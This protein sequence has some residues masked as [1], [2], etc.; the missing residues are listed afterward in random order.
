MGLRPILGERWSASGLQSVR[1]LAPLLFLLV[2]VACQPPP[3]PDVFVGYGE[4]KQVVRHDQRVVIAHEAI[5]DFF[6]AKTSSFAL[7]APALADACVPGQRV[8]FT[9][10]RTSQT[11]YL[12]AVQNVPS[13]EPGERPARSETAGDARWDAGHEPIP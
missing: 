9:L 1:R 6:P 5:P 7:R 4:V 11:L 13:A 12:V 3:P 8:R 10:E 2:G